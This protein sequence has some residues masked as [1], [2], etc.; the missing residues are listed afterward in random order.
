MKLYA[1][2]YHF[3]RTA[4]MR[5][6]RL[7]IFFFLIALII[8][9]VANVLPPK[10]PVFI[11]NIFAMI[12]VFFH[13]KVCKAMPSSTVDKNDGKDIY[14]SF[15]LPVMHLLVSEMK[16]DNLIK[17]LIK[18]P[19]IQLF[20]QKANIEES[21]LLFNDLSKDVLAQ[22]AFETAQTFKAKYVTTL[23]MFIAY[24]LLIEDEKK[25]LFAKQ[26]KTMD[27]YNILF[28]VRLQ[29][30]EEENPKSV[31]VNFWGGGIGEAFTSGWTPETAKYTNNFTALAVKE[32]PLIRGRE[33]EFKAILEAFSK[34]ENNN[35]L[36][37]GDIGSG[38]ETLVKAVAT[39]S[40]AGKLGRYLS[41]KRFYLLLVGYLTAGVNNRNELELR[42]QSII[43]E[44]SHAQDV[45]LYI[46]DFQNIL[47]GSTYNLDLSGALL[48]Y[49]K[50][51]NMPVIATM[52]IGNFKTYMEKN[53]LREVFTI[54]QLNE[55]RNDTAIQMVLGE[56]AMIEKKY[57]VILSYR[58]VSTAVQLADRYFPDDV[59]PGSAVLLLEN[60]A[61]TVALSPEHP[62]FE[63]TRRKM[64]FDNDVVRKVEET[65]H[66][67]IGTP[68][69]AEIDLLLHLEDKL[70]E[71]VIAQ[72]EAVKAVAEAMRRVRTGMLNQER[73]ISFLFLGPTGVGKTETAKAL[74]QFYFGAEQNMIRLDMSEY[75]DEAGVRRLLGAPPGEGAEVGELTDKIHDHPASLLL[76]D[77]FEK[78]H[79]TIHNLFL[80]VLDD[81][82]LTD[83]KGNTVSFRNAIIIATSNAGSEFIR[84]QVEK[85]TPIDKA[86]H[87]QLVD[88]LQTQNIFKPELLNRFDDVVTFKPL[89]DEQVKTVTKLL[90]DQLAKTMEEQ[91]IKLTFDDAVIEK[92]CQEGFDQE[93]GAR[94]LRRY[95][96][97]TVED[98]IA[99]KKL[100]KELDRGKTGTFS[101]DG[102]GALVL[103]V[104]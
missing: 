45:I 88:Y 38:K 18:F 21:D 30:P 48:P 80:Q 63:K 94:P 72:D 85:K 92:I 71:R 36:L 42:L 34:L 8:A 100:T 104:S 79:P 17:K 66:V 62:F 64:V 7:L 56:A 90:L 55:P 25:L 31:R 12:E 69:G 49:L 68:T 33:G 65:A 91:D 82:R 32:E 28:W 103:I 26:L 97:D 54:I 20:L 102:T 9:G 67:A 24:L 46:P 57:K 23:D 99:Q 29:Y 39:E 40:F 58:A 73:P 70:H 3:Y 37:I 53:P 13:Y 1:S 78:A 96:Q 75:A 98:I 59:L 14:K 101:L 50:D 27:I 52:T 44:L 22:S 51:G 81:G 83:N 61:N 60:V 76:L 74:A 6:V 89:G 86:F 87:K 4:K 35:V 11:F 19:Q 77:E 93:F 41:Y 95:I 10:I 5:T 43:A 2:I 47:G 16:T 84:E 15:T